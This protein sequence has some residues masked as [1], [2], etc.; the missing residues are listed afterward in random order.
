[1]VFMGAVTTCEAYTQMGESDQRGYNVTRVLGG[2]LDTTDPSR[3]KCGSRNAE[4]I[5]IYLLKVKAAPIQ[6]WTGPGGFRRLRVPEFL[7]TRHMKMARLQP[8][9]LY[10][11]ARK[12]KTPQKKKASSA[13]GKPGCAWNR[14]VRGIAVLVRTS[15]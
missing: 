14:G 4:T 5:Q 2:G 12:F 7:D 11:S 1:M 3:N 9:A 13:V 15:A 8:Y 10:L 6:A